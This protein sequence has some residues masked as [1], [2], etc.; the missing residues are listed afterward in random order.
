MDVLDPLVQEA[1]CAF[2]G[3]GHMRRT[4]TGWTPEARRAALKRRRLARA[5]ERERHGLMP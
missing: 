2:H 5:R 3:R 4:P 1:H